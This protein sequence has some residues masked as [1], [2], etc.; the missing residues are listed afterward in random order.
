M[1]NYAH[2][3]TKIRE[4]PW[5]MTPE[6]L[7]V[8]LSIFEARMNGKI[9]SEEEIRAMLA[10]QDYGSDTEMNG[11]IVDGVGILPIYGPI[12]GKANLMTQLSGATSLEMFKSDLNSMLENPKVKSILLDIDS[13]GG[14]S[15]LVKSTGDM[16]YNSRNIKPVDAVANDAAG[17]AAYWLASQASRLF[18]VP[19]GKVGSVGAYTVHED[20]SVADAHD[21]IKYTFISAGPYKTEGNPHE[22]LSQEGKEYRQEMIDELY[23]DFIDNVARGRG[24]TTDH[25]RLHFGGGRM[26]PEK[27]ALEAGMVDGIMEFEDAVAETSKAGSTQ[28]AIPQYVFATGADTAISVSHDKLQELVKAHFQLSEAGMEHSDPGTGNPPTPKQREDDDVAIQSGSRRGDLPDGFPHVDVGDQ[29]GSPRA[30]AIEN[31][32]NMDEETQK[33]LYAL[34][35]VESEDAFVLAVEEL[36]ATSTALRGDTSRAAQEL[37][38]QSKYPD[39][40]ARM[41]E[42]D[43]KLLDADAKKFVSELMYFQTIDGEGNK[44][45]TQFGLSSLASETVEQ[46]YT[47]FATGKGGLEEFTNVMNALNIGLVQYGE[48]GSNI[49]VVSET[50]GDDVPSNQLNTVEGSQRV[51]AAFATKIKEIQSAN[52][53]LSYREALAKASTDYPQLADAY[54]RS[55]VNERTS[56]A[57]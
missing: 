16:I 19:D 42:N 13:P 50:A 23:A 44:K 43:S 51:R 56:A 55:I 18:V 1:R 49:E 17:S 48:I 4:T 10:G 8:I 21:G 39:I 12:F 36:H 32:G 57:S 14:T 2:I 37:E 53:K 38:F 28:V 27:R 24:K 25:V 45:K 33:K 15:S 35:G 9:T 5:L 40:W 31:G 11:Q 30:S 47:A 29:P 54:Q 52:P 34:L 22:P 7:E 46:A 26:V 20:Q 6:S 3:A 41:Q